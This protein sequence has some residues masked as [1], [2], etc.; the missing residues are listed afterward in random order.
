MVVLNE[1]WTSLDGVVLIYRVIVYFVLFRDVVLLT[2][3][4]FYFEV[5]HYFGP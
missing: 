2:L 5:D 4:R 1:F 3:K